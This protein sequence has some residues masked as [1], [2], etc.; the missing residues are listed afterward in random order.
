MSGEPVAL[1]VSPPSGTLGALVR[2]LSSLESAGLPRHALVGGV[3]VMVRLSHA[4]RA[5]QDLDEVV[6]ASSPSAAFL[7][8]GPGA[9]EHR[10]EFRSAGPC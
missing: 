10:V 6:E 7:I 8:A 5:T 3:A 9:I 2:A 1:L 4:H